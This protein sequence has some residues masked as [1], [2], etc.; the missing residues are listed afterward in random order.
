M[1]KANSRLYVVDALRGFAIVSIILLH[2]IQ[3]F[4]FN[5]PVSNGPAWMRNLD[6]IITLFLTALFS[7]KSYGIF[8][9]LFGLTYYIQSFNQQQKGIDFRKRFAWRLLILSIFGFVNS[10]FY[11]GDIISF[12]A[13]FGFILIPLS[14]LSNKSIIIIAV[15]LILQPGEWIRLIWEFI[16]PGSISHSPSP[17]IHYRKMWEYIAGDSLL[18]TWICNLTTGK[19]ATILYCWQSG[20]IFQ[21]VGLFLLGMLAGRK[22]IFV[23]T[24]SSIKFWT[25]SLIITLVTFIPIFVLKKLLSQFA[26]NYESVTPLV[27]ILESLSNMIFM[28]FLVSGFVLLFHNVHFSK[29]L[30]FFG[31]YGQMSLTNYIM[32]SIIGSYVYF[33]YGLGLFKSAGATYCLLIGLTVIALQGIFSY[34]WLKNHKRGPLEAIWHKLTWIKSV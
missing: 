27:N 9:L 25:R 34:F 17:W 14:R 26:S 18:N 23:L 24:E 12:Y 28:L 4:Y 30:K 13:I 3:H 1:T 15:I 16:N 32:Q 19:L 2:H 5:Y 6:D 22:A 20:R 31:V 21:T 7:G 33:G 8:A 11:A 29:Y 10:A